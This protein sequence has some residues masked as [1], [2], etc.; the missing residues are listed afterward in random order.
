MTPRICRLI[1][2][3]AAGSAAACATA[4][5]M[6]V[7]RPRGFYNNAVH[8]F[9]P[10]LD[11]RENGVRYARWTL[12][13]TAWETGRPSQAST[14][15]FL[16]GHLDNMPRFPPAPELVAPH[17]AREAPSLFRTFAWIESYE[18]EIAD[19]LAAADA[20]PTRTRARIEK[21]TNDYRSEP[22]A[23]GAPEGSGA[24]EGPGAPRA[25]ESGDWL[26]AAAAE[27][28]L[29]GDFSAQ[30]WKIRSLIDRFDTITTH[31]DAP[32]P[33]G[34]Y[35]ALAPSFTEAYPSAASI[36]D[37]GIAFRREIL[38]AL[39]GA[40]RNERTERVR[41]VAGRYG[42]TWEALRAR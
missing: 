10:D 19:A 32:I 2:L 39:T 31:P 28:F 30:R 41:S 7:F 5:R 40:S 3:I 35:A 21:A 8:R 25:I 23:L 6:S 11:Q 27:S 33:E 36:L 20:S 34:G 1:V 38:A 42:Q 9:F 24:S 12:L 37:R 4:R 22:C 15:Q 26:F 14:A 18:R 16:L 29:G 13:E 17:L